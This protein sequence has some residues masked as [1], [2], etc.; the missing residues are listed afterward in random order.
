MTGRY[1]L[2]PFSLGQLA[3]KT[4]Q[5]NV[6]WWTL[7]YCPETGCHVPQWDS[8]EPISF[9]WA[10]WTISWEGTRSKL[11][12]QNARGHPISIVSSCTTHTHTHP[13]TNDST[14]IPHHEHN[15]L[16]LHAHSIQNYM[17][18]QYL[19]SPNTL[20][21]SFLIPHSHCYCLNLPLSLVR[22]TITSEG[23]SPADVFADSCTE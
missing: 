6:G 15:I 16:I 12:S 19:Y 22:M 11:S 7:V 8:C 21:P 13:H 5:L 20:H 14:L 23:L 9:P 10:V 17:T 18:T 4:L 3:V 1:N 2:I